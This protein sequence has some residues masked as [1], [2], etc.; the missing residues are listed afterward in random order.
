MPKGL[1][2]IQLRSPAG[3]VN[4]EDHADQRR[5]AKGQQHSGHGDN[6]FHVRKMFHGKWQRH[7]EGHADEAAADGEHD[8][9]HRRQPFGDG[10][11][12]EC[13]RDLE[14]VDATL[15]NTPGLSSTPLTIG[16]VSTKP[17]AIKGGLLGVLLGESEE[18]VFVERVFPGSAADRAKMNRG[19]VIL[20]VNGKEVENRQMLIDL[21]RSHLPGETLKFKIKRGEEQVEIDATLGRESDV[22]GSEALPRGDI[23]GDQPRHQQVTRLLVI[24]ALL[25]IQYAHRH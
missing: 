5:D 19:D 12:G 18:S 8:G 17:R 4:A 22:F 1:D 23:G 21:V 10:S 20:S 2:G 13:D 11:H 6:R 9:Q 16:V 14:I 25:R 7:A 3:G 15:A 24:P